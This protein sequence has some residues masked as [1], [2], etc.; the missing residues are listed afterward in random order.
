MILNNW[1]QTKVLLIR[2]IFMFQ[3]VE[4]SRLKS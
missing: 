2:F 4:N 1:V 3:I